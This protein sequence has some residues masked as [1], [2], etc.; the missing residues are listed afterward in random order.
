MS[1]IKPLPIGT[2]DFQ[3]VLENFYYVDITLLIKKVLDRRASTLL[4]PHPRRFEKTDHLRGQSGEISPIFRFP[5][6]DFP[7]VEGHKMPGL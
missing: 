6:C 5:P 7:K 4:H 3:D 1:S 2:P